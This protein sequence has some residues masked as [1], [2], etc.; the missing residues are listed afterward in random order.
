MVSRRTGGILT[1][2]V[3]SKKVENLVTGLIK[4]IPKGAKLGAKKIASMYADAYLKQMAFAKAVNPGP[5]TKPSINSWT[6]R[7]F[8]ELR[9]QIKSPH[10]VGNGFGVIV[11]FPLI[12]L[13]RMQ[14]HFVSLKAGRSIT[15]WAA[16]KLGKTS[17]VLFTHQHPWINNANRRARKH[18]RRIAVEEI[19]KSVKKARR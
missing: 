14:G 10:R 18:I 12:S 16:T 8:T 4:E 2:E 3:D 9:R 15:R 19:D 1:I 6:G 11:P 13:D 17:G 7:S 5:L